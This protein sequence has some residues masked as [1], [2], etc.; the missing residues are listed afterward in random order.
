MQY[1]DQTLMQG[2]AVVHRARRHPLLF[3]RPAIVLFVSLGFSAFGLWPVGAILGPI[4]L[5]DLLITWVAWVS[6]EY[7]VTNMRVVMKRGVVQRQTSETLILKVESVDV[8]QGLLGQ[9]LDFGDVVLHGTGGTA[10]SFATIARPLEFRRHVQ[11][12]VVRATR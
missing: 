11:E 9:M 4:G 2:E 10:E 8:R 12:Q 1:V 3:L 7:A 5:I 6:T